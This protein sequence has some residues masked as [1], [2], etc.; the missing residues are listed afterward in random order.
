MVRESVPA[1]TTSTHSP[2]LHSQALL[3]LPDLL[4]PVS[5]LSALALPSHCPPH[6][7]PGQVQWPVCLPCCLQAPHASPCPA[8]IVAL[9]L[10]MASV[11]DLVS[12]GSLLVGPLPPFH[13]HCSPYPWHT[14]VT[15]CHSLNTRTIPGGSW[16]CLSQPQ[17]TRISGNPNHPRW[18]YG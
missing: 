2:P 15:P 3:H 13:C 8:L 11:P 5:H 12:E 16:A 6:L 14:L 7:K 4:T 9:G 18:P 10:S 1:Y 17:L